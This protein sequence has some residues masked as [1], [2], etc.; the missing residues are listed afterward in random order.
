MMMM[1][2]MMMMSVTYNC[3][4]LKGLTDPMTIRSQDEHTKP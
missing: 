4:Q 2:M 1:M 3:K